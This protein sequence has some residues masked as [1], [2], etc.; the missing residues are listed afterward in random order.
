MGQVSFFVVL[1]YRKRRKLSRR[2]WWLLA[3]WRASTQRVHYV[4]QSLRWLVGLAVQTE[5]RLWQLRCAKHWFTCWLLSQATPIST[6]CTLRYFRRVLTTFRQRQKSVDVGPGLTIILRQLLNASGPFASLANLHRRLLYH[7]EGRL[8]FRIINFCDLRDKLVSLSVFYRVFLV[9]E[10][11]V[12]F[13]LRLRLS[14]WKL[15]GYGIC[16]GARK[17]SEGT[18]LLGCDIA[19][20]V[21][22]LKFWRGYP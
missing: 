4:C 12:A 22:N 13:S 11:T 3:V 10:G 15:A 5:C 17:D 16:G 6:T 18:S 8:S 21:V 1:V 9:V 7:R 2:D 19:L 20:C 14:N